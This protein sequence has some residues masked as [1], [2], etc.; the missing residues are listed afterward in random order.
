MTRLKDH[1]RNHILVKR[2]KKILE[3]LIV[4]GF[5]GLSALEMIT[6]FWEGI[7]KGSIITRAS[8]ISFKII[9][10]LAPTF[11]LLLTLIPFIP[12]DDFQE[13]VLFGIKAL[14]P[15]QTYHLVEDT[16]NGL[17]RQKHS[18]FL[19]ISFLLGIYYASNSINAMLQGLRES[20]FL[21]KRQ[22][23]LQ[24]RIYSIVLLLVLP[25]FLGTALL[26]QT[27]SKT[28]VDWMIARDW[29][30]EGIEVVLLLLAK[31]VAV[32]LLLILAIS[33]LYNI[34][35]AETKKW[36]IISPGALFASIGIIVA[37]QGFAFYV[38]NFGQFNRF[39]GSLTAV[40]ILLLWIYFNNVILLLGFELNVSI[41]QLRK[42]RLQ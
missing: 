31:W 36:M 6:F 42:R 40:I 28:A 25:V 17:V 23:A 5:H 11:I 15:P 33:T 12:I 34:A 14:L 41:F 16:L 27:L 7:Q 1:I 2:L 30:T 22:N 37:S 13:N 10:A 19:S 18:T 39:Y 35:N 4:P 3:D 26:V 8:A 20:H 32:A 38:N 21:V 9:L 29:I 24:Q